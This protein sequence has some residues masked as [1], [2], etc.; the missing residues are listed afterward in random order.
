M[1]PAGAAPD[2]HY[3]GRRFGRWPDLDQA[4]PRRRVI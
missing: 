3:F 4:S 1:V 2:E